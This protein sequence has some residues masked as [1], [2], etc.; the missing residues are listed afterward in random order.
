MKKTTTYILTGIISLLGSCSSEEN[1]T[2]DGDNGRTPITLSARLDGMTRAANDLQ[3]STFAVDEVGV[4]FKKSD[5][6]F[7]AANKAYT[8]ASDGKLTDPAGEKY[9]FPTDGTTLSVYAYAPYNDTA[10]PTSFEVKTDQISNENY[11]ASDI[12]YGVPSSAV[13]PFNCDNVVLNFT[14]KCAKVVV[15]LTPGE[16]FTI[17]DLSPSMLMTSEVSTAMT[18]K[19]AANGICEA[20]TDSKS[21]ITLGIYGM[22]D[23]GNPTYNTETGTLTAAAVLIPQTIPAGTPFISLVF[24]EG[25]SSNSPLVLSLPAALTLEAGKE[26]HFNLKANRSALA[27]KGDMA[28]TDWG[29][30]DNGSSNLSE[31]M[32]INLSNLTSDLTVTSDCYLT[33]ITSK[34][35]TIAEG[36]TL[37]L[38]NAIIKSNQ[39]VCEGNAKIYLKG[40]NKVTAPSNCSGIEAGP[41]GTTLTIY[42]DADGTIEVQ[43]GAFG[44]GIG[45]GLWNSCGNITINGGN[46]TAKGGKEGSGIGSGSE[47]SCGSITINGG[48][49]TANGGTCAAGIGSGYRNSTCGNITIT[50]GTV[51]ANGGSGAAGIGSGKINTKCGDITI[52]GGNVTATSGYAG[53]GIG[54]GEQQASCGNITIKGGTVTATEGQNG[55]GIGSG[56]NNSSCGDIIINGGTVT[57]TG[58]QHGAGIGSGYWNSSCG[59]INVAGGNVTAIGGQYGAGIGSGRWKSSCGNITVTGETNGTLSLSAKAGTNAYC[60]GKGI[61]ANAPNSITITN[62]TITLDDSNSSAQ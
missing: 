48:T 44:S 49:V 6:T 34:K 50:G 51:T 54:S 31:A 3:G 22:D 45:S 15:S 12:L 55:A 7:L 33:G 23:T 37:T 36:V 14:H 28:I 27:L 20:F 11:I 25:S 19:D 8:I 56:Y 2:A 17:D 35:I 58:G 60:I 46:I 4:T 9:Y 21:A 39:I 42:G 16:G 52:T 41:E 10:M 40:E 57:A 29:S 61:D 30:V 62:A 18:L 5:D 59:N 26:Y 24:T 43:G 47:N 53:A 38:N 13:S 1:T 32:L